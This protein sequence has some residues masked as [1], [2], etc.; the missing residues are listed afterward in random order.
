MEALAV[1]VA[2]V[3]GASLATCGVLIAWF[4]TDMLVEYL[5]LFRLSRFTYIK[6]YE[7][8]FNEN[9]DLTYLEFAYYK[10]PTF[11]NKLIS[12]SYCLGFWVSIVFAYIA[13]FNILMGFVC[14]P[15]S[16][17]LYFSFFKLFLKND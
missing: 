12:C 7:E 1:Q 9:P 5:K 17:F 11:F 13:T 15:M 6:E 3:I 8:Q 10:E 2:S 14:Y 16:L 4:H